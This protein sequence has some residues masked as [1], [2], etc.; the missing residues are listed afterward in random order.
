[1]AAVAATI[2]VSATPGAAAAQDDALGRA[3]RDELARSIK[4]LKVDQLERPYYI[5]YRVREEQ[6]FDVSA[7]MGSLLGGSESRGRALVPEVR[8]GDYAFDNTNFMGMGGGGM[9]I[10]FGRGGAPMSFFGG[11]PLDDNY[12]EL[13]RQIWL[14]TDAAYKEAAETFAAKK[15]ALLNRARRDTLADLSRVTSTQTTDE[16]PSVAE[17]RS[18]AESLVRD[19]SAL[20]ELTRLSHSSVSMAVSNSRSRLITSEGT[21]SVE[22]RPLITISASASTQAVDGEP[23]QAGLHVF[24][25]SM[26][27]VPSRDQLRRDVRS[28]A[29]RLDSL[30]SAPVLERYNGPVII[31]G[32]AAGELFA[33]VFA[34][35]LSGRR[36]PEGGPDFA[37]MMEANGRGVTSFTEKLGSR[38]LPT[39]LSV[40]DDPTISERNGQP[41]FG[42]YRVDDDGVPGVRKT[43]V[44]NGAL[45]LVLTTRTP[46]QGSSQS[47]GNHRGG[48]ASPSNLIVTSTTAV[49]D[50]ELKSKLLALVKQRGLEYGVV[51]RELGGASMIAD[52]P[53]SF[54]SAMRGRGAGRR[55]L[56]AYRVY[57]DGREELVRGVRLSDVTA[58]SFKDI[59]AVSSSETVLHRPAIGSSD[60]PF[61]VEMMEMMQDAGP[62]VALASY[63]VP[64]MLF[65]DLSLTRDT[66]E[67]P[68]LPLSGPPGVQ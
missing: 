19:L 57:P 6:G 64:A 43:V 58:Q 22:S 45:K 20:P 63:V 36:R 28:F 9:G 25:R 68:K 42:N 34:P 29:L 21:T 27:S 50:P 38:V 35:A 3:L 48:G 32:R 18:D 55:V 56:L 60:L 12:I 16:L 33:E 49:S 65:E 37:A 10:S 39:F 67:R 51:I 66:G 61:P 14:A 62:S 7:T 23:L 1:M 15:A 24:V 41:L 44:D 40:L 53:M 4:E 2:L 31:E 54:I 8:V 30:R 47:T 52:D 17:S 26:Q 46:V 13:R 11:L 5:A 59:L